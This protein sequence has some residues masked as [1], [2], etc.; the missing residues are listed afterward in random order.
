[1]AISYI[2]PTAQGSAN[3]TSPTNAYA[4]TSV[5]SA[6][7]DATSG[8]TI[9]FVDVT[10]TLTDHLNLATAITYGVTYQPQTAGGVTITGATGS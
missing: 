3:G 6:E 10:Y 7:A 8:G 9:V 1:M 2:A 5:A 4:F